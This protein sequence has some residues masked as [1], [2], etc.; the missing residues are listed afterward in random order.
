MQEW[1]L[2]LWFFKLDSGKKESMFIG[3]LVKV[4]DKYK[5]QIIQ[6]EITSGKRNDVN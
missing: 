5:D 4:R 1:T 2:D 3:I 6:N